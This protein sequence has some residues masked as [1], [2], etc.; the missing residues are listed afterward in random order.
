MTQ[1]LR[2]YCFSGQTN[3]YHANFS[4]YA[5]FKTCL[6]KYQI[7]LLVTCL[8]KL[9]SLI[10]CLISEG[11][12]WRHSTFVVWGACLASS[13]LWFSVSSCLVLIFI[14]QWANKQ[15]DQE[16]V[17]SVPE[18]SPHNDEQAVLPT[19]ATLIP[20]VLKLFLAW[21]PSQGRTGHVLF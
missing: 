8:L 18:K 9:R 13:C 6:S 21:L 16:D 20:A 3:R 5:N 12:A 11:R 17:R 4:S 14:T 1:S 7:L 2:A 15:L 19:K 10:Q